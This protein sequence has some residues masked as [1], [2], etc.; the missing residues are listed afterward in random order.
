M[1]ECSE[2]MFVVIA[3]GIFEFSDRVPAINKRRAGPLGCRDNYNYLFCLVV[4]RE[5]EGR[6]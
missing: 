2:R 1:G 4:R 5:W 3:D 6:R